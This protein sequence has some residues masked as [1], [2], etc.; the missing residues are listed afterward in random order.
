M[1]SEIVINFPAF[2]WQTALQILQMFKHIQAVDHENV[3]QSSTL[4]F[5]INL[6]AIGT[7]ERDNWDDIYSDLNIKTYISKYL[8]ERLLSV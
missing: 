8:C 5:D 6:H 4:P 3:C 2:V 1:E 7:F